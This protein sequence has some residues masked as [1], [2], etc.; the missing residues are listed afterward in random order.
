[1]AKPQERMIAAISTFPRNVFTAI[2]PVS[3]GWQPMESLEPDRYDSN[4]GLGDVKPLSAAAI[5]VHW[6]Q[7][8]SE[9][10]E[11]KVKPF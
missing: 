4:L 7:A 3:F 11:G 9:G 5:L 1:M 8:S 2:P 6:K 10:E